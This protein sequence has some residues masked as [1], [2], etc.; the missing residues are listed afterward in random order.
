MT[1]VKIT[2]EEIDRIMKI[3]GHIK[4]SIF[5]GFYYYVLDKKGK[6]GVEKVKKRLKELGPSFDL[7]LEKI[8]SFKW[9]PHSIATIVC[10]AI[11]EVFDWNEEVAYDMG[12]HNLS[13]SSL[14]RMLLRYF[15][16]EKSFTKHNMKYWKRQ[17]DYGEIETVE[18]NNEEK[19]SITRIRSFKK[20]HRVVYL[21][22]MGF[23]AR[24]MELTMNVKNAKVE[25]TKCLFWGDPYDEFKTTWE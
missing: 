22:T 21:Y 1:K 19:Y 23:M 7:D 11:L 10:L 17:V 15:V 18:T 4:G 16:T 3:K 6:E 25:Q 12:Y 20:F 24:V 13:H 9:Y 14:A 2:K 5:Q 8:D